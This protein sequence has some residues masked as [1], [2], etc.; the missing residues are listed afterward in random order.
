LLRHFSDHVLRDGSWRTNAVQWFCPRPHRPRGLELVQAK[1]ARNTRPEAFFATFD[2]E[3]L[4][5][6]IPTLRFCTTTLLCSA[7]DASKCLMYV[8][9]CA[10][11]ARKMRISDAFGVIQAS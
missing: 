8:N 5:S 3:H 2:P 10:S 4:A 11:T 1:R 6:R 7:S 9:A